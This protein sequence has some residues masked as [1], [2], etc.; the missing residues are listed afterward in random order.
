MNRN[1]SIPSFVIGCVSLLA[2]AGCVERKE[3][4]TIAADQGVTIQLL[5]RAAPADLVDGDAMPS[6]EAGWDVVQTVDKK[7]DEDLRHVLTAERTFEPG[8]T[9]PGS[10]APDGDPEADLYLRFPTTLRT[11]QRTDGIYYHFRRVYTPRRWAYVRHWE[12]LRD[13]ALEDIPERPVEELTPEERAKIAEGVAFVEAH[14]CVEF[15]REAV[16]ALGLEPSPDGWLAARSAILGV[17]AATDWDELIK[18]YMAAPEDERDGYIEEA[19]GRLWT[20]AT[21]AML[22]AMRTDP[23]LD[24]AR[25]AEFEQAFYRAKR[26]YH[27]T[28]S[29]GGHVFQIGVT[30]PGEVVAHNANKIAETGA[31]VWEFNGDAVRDRPHELLVTSRVPTSGETE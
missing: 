30:M 23:G 31:M 28:N 4:I 1:Q 19:T 11:E 24:D 21:Q 18:Q 29:L 5:Y 16:D 10:Y 17:Y 2:A 15:A 22:Q 14:R 26:Y 8:E 12:D 3:Q 27:V 20:D 25:L 6:K 9:L 7:G 13:Q